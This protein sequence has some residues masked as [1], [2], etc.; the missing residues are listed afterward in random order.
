M[1]LDDRGP[2]FRR[3]RFDLRWY[4]PEKLDHRLYDG[5]FLDEGQLQQALQES[6]AQIAALTAHVYAHPLKSSPRPVSCPQA[7]AHGPLAVA[8]G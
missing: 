7:T 5:E 1:A 6:G 8:F 3:A 4:W 2:V